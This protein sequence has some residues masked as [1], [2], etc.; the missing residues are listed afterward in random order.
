MWSTFASIRRSG[1]VALL[2]LASIA[3][4]TVSTAGTAPADTLLIIK[5]GAEPSNAELAA[6]ISA[7]TFD[8]GAQRVLISRDDAFADA[9]ASGVLQ[10][11]APLLLVPTA[12]PLP[13]AVVVEIQRLGATEAVVLGGAAA[14]SDA[15]ASELQQLGLAVARRHGPSRLETALEIAAQEAA[16]ADTVLLARAFGSNPDD[17]SQAFADALAAGGLAAR[18]GAPILLTESQ[19]LSSPTRAHLVAHPQITTVRILGGTAAVSQVVEDEL[20]ALGLMVLRT[21]GASRAGTAVEI[22]KA[23]GDESA[24]DAARVIVTDGTGENAWAAGFALAAHAARFD[25]PILLTAAGTVPPETGA[26]LASG[27]GG[28]PHAAP[29][30]TCA[31]APVVCERARIAAQLPPRPVALAPGTIA[32]GTWHTCAL[33]EGGR[34]YCWGRDSRGQLGDGEDADV[35]KEEPQAVAGDLTFAQIAAG[36]THTCGLTTA[37][38]A[39]CWGQDNQGQL[40]DGDDD[41]GDAVAP[42]PV[43]GGLTFTRITAGLAHTCALDADGQAHCWGADFSGQGGDG[44]QVDDVLHVPTPVAGGLAFADLSAGGSHTCG[45]ATGGAAYCWGSQGDG[46]LGNGRD[47]LSGQSEPVR[48]LGGLAFT[49]V[50]AGSRNSC[51]VT[52]DGA[53]HC[54]GGDLRGTLGNGSDAGEAASQPVAVAGGLAFSTI[55]MSNHVCGLTTDGQAHCWGGDSDGQLGNGPDAG[56]AEQPTT[57]VG[58]LT[59]VALSTG[60]SHTCGVTDDGAAYCWGDN[61]DGQLGDGT[62]AVDGVQ[63]PTPV[64]G[65]I[66]FGG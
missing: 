42:T 16:A 1:I 45:L 49:S 59:F 62:A 11:D 8:T 19:Q 27:I 41:G 18:S 15:V 3:A 6:T 23:A 61:R 37:G 28:D 25:A 9:L 36:N 14:V 4:P 66:P 40:G 63:S 57:V 24:A 48:V 53:A 2:L 44:G 17:P 30:L 31:D 46:R 56:D 13:N 20:R 33:A 7:E 29:V 39:H 38:A 55:S 32:A 21:A 35:V 64:T 65:A 5:E 54:W 51:G 43:S 26:F 22:A 47:D 52:G 60:N 50:A 10:G 34:A 58:G 12:G